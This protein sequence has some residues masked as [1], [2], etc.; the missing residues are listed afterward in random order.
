[1]LTSHCLQLVVHI[2]LDLE[3]ATSELP[4]V[5]AGNLESDP[6][7]GL[8]TNAGLPAAERKTPR[9]IIFGGGIPDDEVERVGEAVRAGPGAGVRLVRVARQEVLDAGA[10]KPNPEVIV[11]ILRGKLAG[12]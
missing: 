3:T 1:M 4:A 10:E 5:C 2:C 11:G 6:A 12:L 9:A 8:G 7:S